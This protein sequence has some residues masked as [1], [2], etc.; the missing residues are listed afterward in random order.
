MKFWNAWK[1]TVSKA[2]KENMFQTSSGIIYIT[3]FPIKLNYQIPSSM[4]D[5]HNCISM[6]Q[7]YNEKMK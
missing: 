3:S 1:L 2:L 5:T 6:V 7:K 4:K